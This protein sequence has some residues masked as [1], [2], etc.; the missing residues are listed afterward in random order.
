MKLLSRSTF[1]GNINCHTYSTLSFIGLYDLHNLAEGLYGTSR[2]TT[3]LPV[4]PVS[5][6][7]VNYRLRTDISDCRHVALVFV[8]HVRRFEALPLVKRNRAVH[9][10]LL[11]FQQPQ[12]RSAI[13]ILQPVAGRPSHRRARA[14]DQM[15]LK[16]MSWMIAAVR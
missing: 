11:I 15:Q 5:R 1:A 8:V 2:S 3:S 4:D 9:L 13:R 7:R 12:K 6:D 10:T 14:F 16:G